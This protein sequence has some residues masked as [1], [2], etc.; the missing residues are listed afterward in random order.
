[1]AAAIN[2]M[3]LRHLRY[4]SALAG[5][6]HFGRA[7]ERL[8]ITQPTLSS[9]IKC[10]EEELQVTLFKRGTR[11]VELTEAGK[12]FLDGTCN[13]LRNVADASAAAML[14]ARGKR[15]RISIGVVGL[16]TLNALPP[17]IRHF[18]KHF[19]EVVPVFHEAP[20]QAQMSKLLDGSLDVGIVRTTIPRQL[21]SKRLF[22][23][24]RIVAMPAGHR[25]GRKKVV[26][27]AGLRDDAFI[28][29]PR[30]IAPEGYDQVI[31]ACSRAGF[32]PHVV[33]EAQINL[34][35]IG[36]V[37]AGLGIAILPSASAQITHPGVIYR[38]IKPSLRVNT[39]LVWSPKS[40]Q[41]K[42]V[43]RA[44]VESAEEVFPRPRHSSRKVP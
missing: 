37:A 23:D 35:I 15:G 32:S 30:A 11:Q 28:M 2:Q 43:V 7:A 31:T 40:F 26:A 19:P 16:A 34:T 27:L 22:Q 1:M 24:E 17:L 39:A 12:A 33:Q 36:L 41:E 4:F 3:E 8:N 13:I 5:E 6:L 38:P 29:Y 21:E 25:H 20:A 9:Q 44:F 42:P 14:A 18:C 10:L